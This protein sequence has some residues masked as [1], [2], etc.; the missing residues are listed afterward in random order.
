MLA[1]A[2]THRHHL[3]IDERVID[4]IVIVGLRLF[5]VCSNLCCLLRVAKFGIEMHWYSKSL[6]LQHAC[7]VVRQCNKKNLT[8][9][10][11]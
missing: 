11:N 1:A 3:Q 2:I 8:R 7:V 4:N 10:K 5:H 9:S 6:N